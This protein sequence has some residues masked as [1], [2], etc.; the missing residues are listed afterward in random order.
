LRSTKKIVIVTSEFPPKPGGI[1]NHAY[2]LAKQLTSND[3]EVTVIADQRVANFEKEKEFDTCQ[4]FITKRIK[5]EKIRFLMYLNR[6]SK[7]F[8]TISQNDVVIA[9]GKFSLWAVAF[10]TFFYNKKYIAVIHGSEVN[11]KK[12]FLKK[13]I[14]YSL[15]RF[16]KIIAVS[17][18]TKSI[19]DY[20]NLKN[21]KVIS[22]GFDLIESKNINKEKLSGYPNLITVGSVTERKGQKNVIKMLSNLTEKYPMLQY[23]IVGSPLKRE[24]FITLA[25]TMNVDKHIIFYGMVG[26]ERKNALLKGSDIFVMLS[27][28]TKDG[29]VEGFGIA[30]IEANSLRIPT[31][32]AKGCGIEDAIDNFKSGILIDN[33]SPIAFKKAIVDILN[34]YESFQDNSER[35]ASKFTWDIIIDKYIKIIEN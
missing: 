23:H 6:I 11:F 24:A 4:P 10:A 35:W 21:I 14:D 7:I 12:S 32:G 5:I 18:Y 29:D 8:G 30:L 27:E 16:H 25:K 34:D 9:S 33:K 2:N 28:N 20:L 19:I 1:G 22:N 31:I 26:D 13:S 17:K 15:N 3:F